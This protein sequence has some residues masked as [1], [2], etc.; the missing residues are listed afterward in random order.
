MMVVDLRNAD[1]LTNLI[2]R[3][4]GQGPEKDQ[5][6]GHD[7]TELQMP[8]PTPIRRGTRRNDQNVSHGLSKCR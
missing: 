6:V 1:D 2:R 5:N 3:S 8:L 4:E 7:D